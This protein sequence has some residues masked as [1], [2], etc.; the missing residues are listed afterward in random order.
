M[1]CCSAGREPNTRPDEGVEHR[2][3]ILEARHVRDQA[4]IRTLQRA[5]LTMAGMMTCDKSPFGRIPKELLVDMESIGADLADWVELASDQE[6]IDDTVAQGLNPEAEARHVRGML[7][8]AVTHAKDRKRIERLERAVIAASS[9]LP[10]LAGGEAA[11]VLASI[12]FSI[13]ADLAEI[14]REQGTR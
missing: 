8:E 11:A 12:S 6:I 3:A 13:R 14:D 4:Q 9:M 2:L 10:K 1:H 5:I 7:L